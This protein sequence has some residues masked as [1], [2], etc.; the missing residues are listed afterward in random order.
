MLRKHLGIRLVSVGVLIITAWD[1]LVYG[2]IM[3]TRMPTQYIAAHKAA[4]QILRS[5]G[6][7]IVFNSAV[8][9]GLYAIYATRRSEYTYLR[10]YVYAMALAAL[11]T[12]ILNFV[13]PLP[14]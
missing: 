2:V 5:T 14:R 10:T 9:V 3:S 13:L 7:F 1:L 6:V 4:R 8:F 11:V 12:E